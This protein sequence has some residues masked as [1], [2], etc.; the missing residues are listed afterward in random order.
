MEKSLE[1][2]LD[3]KEVDCLVTQKFYNSFCKLNCSLMCK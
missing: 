2:I 1:I 3:N